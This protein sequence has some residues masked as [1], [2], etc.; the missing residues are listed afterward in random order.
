M[1]R[2]TLRTISRNAGTISRPGPLITRP[3]MSR[4]FVRQSKEN[5]TLVETGPSYWTVNGVVC[6]FGEASFIHDPTGEI[7]S[8]L[9]FDSKGPTPKICMVWDKSELNVTPGSIAF[10]AHDSTGS[11]TH[12]YEKSG[13]VDWV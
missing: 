3:S 2:N 10:Y 7:Y 1:F 4:T 8:T 12:S 5:A 11:N 9:K 13:E 6:P